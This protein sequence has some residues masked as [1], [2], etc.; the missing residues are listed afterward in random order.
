MAKSQKKK[1]F[2]FADECFDPRSKIG[3]GC[4]LI[5]GEDEILKLK[6]SEFKSLSFAT[7]DFDETNAARLEL[8]AV[9]WALDHIDLS[10]RA[11]KIILHTDSKTILGLLE[12]RTKLQKTDYMSAKDG[13]P[14]ANAELLKEFFQLH[15]R[16][17]FEVVEGK[18]HA[19][20]AEVVK[21]ADTALKTRLKSQ[22]QTASKWF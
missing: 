13:I 11:A 6:P 19:L 2:L 1:Y 18:D 3:V 15:D 4:C 20:F 10:P 17:D 7:K 14:L 21:H 12:R 9:N 5:L 22:N 8:E 16:F